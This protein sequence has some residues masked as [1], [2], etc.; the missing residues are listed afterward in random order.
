ML[1]KIK[2]VVRRLI[3]A[4]EPATGQEVTER[5]KRFIEQIVRYPITQEDCI[6]IRFLVNYIM[7]SALTRK[8]SYYLDWKKSKTKSADF[9][10]IPFS[11]R[12]IVGNKIILNSLDNKEGSNK[13]F[14]K[15]NLVFL[16]L[17]KP[18]SITD[19][20]KNVNEENMMQS[21]KSFL[22]HAGD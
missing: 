11:I 5:V 4:K 10:A 2:Q 1:F 18:D 6:K 9:Q 3:Y 14:S 19:I 17:T 21:I 20:K 7:D 8:K 22:R 16:S 13:D 15:G 12:E